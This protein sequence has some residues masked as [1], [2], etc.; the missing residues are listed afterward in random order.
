MFLQLDCFTQFCNFLHLNL[1]IHILNSESIEGRPIPHISWWGGSS[2]SPKIFSITKVVYRA[3]FCCMAK[4]F[5]SAKPDVCLLWNLSW[6]QGRSQR[7]KG[8]KFPPENRKN[9]C[10]K[11]VFF[12]KALFLVTN[13]PKKSNKNKN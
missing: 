5:G 4:I 10:R 11:M 8:E 6:F 1:K 12:P 13:F 7:V 3:L 2:W 9:Y